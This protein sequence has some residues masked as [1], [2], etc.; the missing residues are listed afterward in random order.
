MPNPQTPLSPAV[1]PR[2]EVASEPA[3][4][5]PL[6]DDMAFGCECADPA[7]QI[8][9]WSQQPVVAAHELR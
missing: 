5:W 1:M 2:S 7:L 8:E 9:A 3:M 6:D 4:P